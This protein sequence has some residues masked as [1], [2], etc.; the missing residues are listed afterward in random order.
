MQFEHFIVLIE[1]IGRIGDQ[2]D[3]GVFEIE[4]EPAVQK[5]H[6]NIGEAATSEHDMVDGSWVEDVEW[7]LGEDR[8]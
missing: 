2:F 3:A 4:G 6:G 5:R 8:I 7:N 1:R